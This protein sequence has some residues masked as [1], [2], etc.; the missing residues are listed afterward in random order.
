MV[1]PKVARSA[2]DSQINFLE[3]RAFDD[4]DELESY[5]MTNLSTLK[6]YKVVELIPCDVSV[7]VEIVQKV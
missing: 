7:S 1:V 4:K 6:E 2:Y 3:M 5:I